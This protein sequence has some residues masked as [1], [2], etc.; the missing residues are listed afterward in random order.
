M[1]AATPHAAARGLYTRGSTREEVVANR[2]GTSSGQDR[3]AV[4]ADILRGL[5]ATASGILLDLDGTLVHSEN[6]SQRA[7]QRYF[8]HRGWSVPASVVK[9]FTGRRAPEV[10]ATTPGPWRDEDPHLLTLEVQQLAARIAAPIAPVPGA[11]ELL[12][13]C[14][15]RGLPYTIVTSATRS[16][17]LQALQLL[18]AEPPAVG[19]VTAEDYDR[20]K[21]EPEPFIRGAELLQAEPRHLIAIED[22]PAGI[23]SA[24]RAG[25]GTVIGVST[26][27]TAAQLLALG[28]D[29]TVSNL[30]PLARAVAARVTTA[31]A[32]RSPP[33]LAVRTT[34]PVPTLPDS[35]EV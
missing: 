18:H 5:A 28:A 27:A 11:R 24:R 26:T 30:L 16:W 33:G 17:T 6:A 1:S 25:V 15:A 7:L 19:M 35:T 3:G 12:T 31:N 23:V 4:D 14:A 21:P 29:T 2:Q 32:Y 9:S 20:G 10:F 13:A 34:D 22:S 8:A